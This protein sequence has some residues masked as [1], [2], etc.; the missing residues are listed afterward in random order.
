MLCLPHF[1]DW[2]AQEPPIVEDKKKKLKLLKDEIKASPSVSPSPPRVKKYKSMA[3]SDEIFNSINRGKGSQSSVLCRRL[4]LLNK[5]C[6]N[7]FFVKLVNVDAT[8]RLIIN[9]G[10][11]DKPQQKA[12][13][14]MTSYNIFNNQERVWIDNKKK[15]QLLVCSDLVWLKVDD[16]LFK[17][18]FSLADNPAAHAQLQQTIQNKQHFYWPVAVL[19]EFG[20]KPDALAPSLAVLQDD[21][22][23]YSAA[24]AASK[25]AHEP[26]THPHPRRSSPRCR[27]RT[28]TPAPPLPRSARPAGALC[29]LLQR[30]R[31]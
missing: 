30:R 22:D 2:S 18:L 6:L 24:A 10:F 11:L 9:N 16:G 1:S 19:Q 26:R 13:M 21:L 29:V 8:G 3:L 4:S 20:C 12:K 28:Q 14:F 17:K 23:I 25:Q 31:A 15:H 5:E 7:G 27:A